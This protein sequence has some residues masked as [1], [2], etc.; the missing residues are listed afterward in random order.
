M[1]IIFFLETICTKC[2]SRFSMGENKTNIT[3]LSSD[4]FAQRAVK[5]NKPMQYVPP[6]SPVICS[7]KNEDLY[8]IK[9]IF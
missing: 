6:F 4:E 9:V 2:Q 7:V 1:Q 8:I 3:I 5:V